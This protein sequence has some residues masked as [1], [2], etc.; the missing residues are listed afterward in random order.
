MSGFQLPEIQVIQT[1][2]E[3]WE[4]CPVLDSSVTAGMTIVISGE[5]WHSIP[6]EGDRTI[7]MWG[8]GGDWLLVDFL[9]FS[10][11]F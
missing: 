8:R 2:C 7:L 5:S 6:T 3:L 1:Y 10:R 4:I 11:F 9:C